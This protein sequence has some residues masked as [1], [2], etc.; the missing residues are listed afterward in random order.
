MHENERRSFLL[1]SRDMVV[2]ALTA[3]TLV[4]CASAGPTTVQAQTSLSPGTAAFGWEI[5]NL[6]NNGADAYFPVQRDL[7]LNSVDV[8]LAF[9]P[10]SP[11][12]I[13]GLAEVLCQGAVSRGGAPSFASGPQAYFFPPISPA[14]AAV[15]TY[16]P[17]GLTIGYNPPVQDTFMSVILKSWM[18]VDGTASQAYRHVQ[19]LPSIS[20]K[21][22]DYLVFHMDHS[23]APVDAE[24]QVILVFQ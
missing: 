6:F 13:P 11:P 9:S 18:P 3:G 10:L 7:V 5:S 23:G 12:A 20:L 21:T 24:M 16:N 19:V 22:G 15:Q 1:S 4:A 8:D 2:G 17:S 14:F